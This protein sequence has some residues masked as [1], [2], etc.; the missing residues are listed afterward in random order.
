[1]E[2]AKRKQSVFTRL[3]WLAAF[4]KPLAHH[5]PPFVEILTNITTAF[6]TFL[7]KYLHSAGLVPCGL[8]WR[9]L[10]E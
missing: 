10:H 2:A 6:K 8:F 7:V 4:L 3:I 5:V 1:M 9:L